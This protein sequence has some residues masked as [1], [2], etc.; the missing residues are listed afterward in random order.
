MQHYTSSVSVRGALTRP[1]AIRKRLAEESLHESLWRTLT[2]LLVVGYLCMILAT[3]LDYGITYDEGWHSQY[4]KYVIEWFTSGFRDQN[5]LTY[6]NLMYYGSFFNSISYLATLISPLGFYETGHL[7]NALFGL[8]TVI[9]TYKLGKLIGGPAAGFAAAL[10]LILSPRFYGHAY[11]NPKDIPLA[12]LFVFSLYY[13]AKLIQELPNPSWSLLFKLG[14]ATGLALNTRIGAL[15]L[16]G[17]LGLALL[18]WQALRLLQPDKRENSAILPGL[19]RLGTIFL[20]VSA[21]AYVFM[22]LFWPAA[23]VDPIRQPFRALKYATQ[24]EFPFKVLFDGQ[25][26]LNTQLPWYYQIKWFLITTPEFVLLTVL[27]GL[28]LL[29][30]SL[31]SPAKLLSALE[32]PRNLSL[33]IVIVAVAAPLGYTALT[34]PVDYDGVRHFLFILPLLSILAGVSVKK[35]ADRLGPKPTRVFLALMLASILLTAVDMVRLHPNQYIY[36]NRLFGKGVARA[37]QSFDTDYWG[38]SFKEGVAWVENHYPVPPGSQ[39]VKVA[40]CL[41]SLSTSYYLTDSRFEYIG[42]YNDGQM[43]EQDDPHLFLASPR[44]HC[45]QRKSGEVLYTVTRM[46]ASLMSVIKV[47]PSVSP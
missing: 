4:G 30:T 19:I 29:T 46:G 38:N 24:F 5:A 32:K 20:S 22:L 43:V 12:A 7:I 21:I 16:V 6:W 34:Q 13:L 27:A 15:L 35:L 1:L 10:F 37:S 23:Q 3:F 28:V 33:L 31:K 42:S 45:D 40:S 47:S 18:L 44:W 2:I 9:G 11:N 25:A 14:V 17:Y 8:L 41:Y 26:I 39:K 36:F